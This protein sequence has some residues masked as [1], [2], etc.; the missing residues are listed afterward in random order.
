MT[1]ENKMSKEDM[2]DTILTK[3]KEYSEI[4]FERLEN[5][6]VIKKVRGGYLVINHN[7]LPDA[8]R[9]LITSLKQTK[10][11]V[12]MIISKPPKSFLNLAKMK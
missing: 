9:K 11:G 1:D 10:N 6:G 4:N 3:A 7:K 12:Q 5:D 2:I 8:A